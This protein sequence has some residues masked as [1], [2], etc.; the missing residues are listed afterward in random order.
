MKTDR[1]AE[2]SSSKRCPRTLRKVKNEGY[3]GRI[4]LVLAKKRQVESNDR[5]DQA[6]VEGQNASGRGSNDGR[7]AQLKQ[8]DHL[9]AATSFPV[10]ARHADGKSMCVL[11]QVLAEAVVLLMTKR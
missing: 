1:P 6:E 4:Y 11:G 10:S 8:N 7:K 9:I 2:V 3:W 5:R